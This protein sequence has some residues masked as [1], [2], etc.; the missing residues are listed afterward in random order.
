[1]SLE[2]SEAA[3]RERITL[4][5]RHRSSRATTRAHSWFVRA[6]PT[7]AYDYLVLSTVHLG[8]IWCSTCGRGRAL[9]GSTRTPRSTRA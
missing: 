2:E 8:P 3:Q 1:M 7:R 5:S 6:A 9:R 4:E